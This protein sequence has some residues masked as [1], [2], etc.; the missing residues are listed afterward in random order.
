MRTVFSCFLAILFLWT[1]SPAKKYENKPEVLQWEKD[2][3]ALEKRDSA[4]VDSHGAI[5]FTGSSSIRLWNT[6]SEDMMPY[7]VISRGYGGA[8]LS[9]FAIYCRRI[10]YPHEFK[11]LVIFVANDIT[12]SEDDK[13]PTEVLKLFQ[14][15][16]KQVRAKYETQPIF[17][18]QITPTNSRWN[19]WDKISEA[20][21][22]IKEKCSKKKNLYFIETTDQFIG[23]DGKPRTDLFI[24]DQ[25]HLN[26]E[27]YKLWSSIIKKNL[28]Q[29]LSN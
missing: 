9:D 10:I 14:Y 4:E 8:K 15:V 24:S 19:V 23:P 28:D 29:V 21:R 16:V 26:D 17:F 6:I 22:M 1:C 13:T 18:V 27:G 25:L 5:L 7:P 12:G 2:V 11:A 20:N 3:K